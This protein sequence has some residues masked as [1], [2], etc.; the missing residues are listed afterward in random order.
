[1]SRKQ[2][3]ETECAQE[4]CRELANKRVSKIIGTK[5]A[6]RNANF[7]RNLICKTNSIESLLPLNL[8]S[9]SGMLINIGL[10]LKILQFRS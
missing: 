6:Q 2:A 1:M 3:K 5:H 7:V 4:E 10:Y 8:N 9:L